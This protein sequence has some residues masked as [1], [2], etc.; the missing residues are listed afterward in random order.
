VLADPARLHQ[1]LWNLVKNAVKFTP[2]GGTVTVRTAASAAGDSEAALRTDPPALLIEV[3]DT[4]IGI[5][6]DALPRIFNAFEQG[7]RTRARQFGGLGLGLAISRAL[8][9]AHGGE[10]TAASDGPG[11]GAT[12]ALRLPRSAE[13]AADDSAADT[14]D[15][16]DHG[17]TVTGAADDPTT[18][19]PAGLQ[20]TGRS[21]G[22][23]AGD[24]LASSR[25]LLVEDH[26]DTARM[27]S[28]LLSSSGHSV[29]TATSVAS[30]L[31]LAD[32]H[33]FD[34]LISDIG[35]PDASGYELMEQI[36]R[37]FGIRGIALSGYGMERDMQRSRDAGFSEH[38]VKPINLEQLE[39][40][41]RRVAKTENAPV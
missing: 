24:A 11:A 40:V 16:T 38:L 6:P 35:L 29:E 18:R 9:E 1:V 23:G 12:F 15:T 17:A 3:A 39:A 14:T 28:R 19:A 26:A 2:P 32:Q 41:I 20:T 10:L 25:V 8:V 37:R 13:P 5:A 21:V 7:D 30:A 34:I 31:G 33:P 22:Q 27:L 36:S 4:G